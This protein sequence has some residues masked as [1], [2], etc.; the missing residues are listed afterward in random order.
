MIKFN[1]KRDYLKIFYEM[2]KGMKDDSLIYYIPLPDVF[3]NEND[4][5]EPYCLPISDINDVDAT[6]NKGRLIGISVCHP[7]EDNGNI[8]TDSEYFYF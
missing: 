4:V 3:R 6:T 5:D 1:E 8:F 7:Y 2:A